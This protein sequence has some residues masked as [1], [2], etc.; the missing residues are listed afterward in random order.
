MEKVGDKI[1][2]Q[3]LGEIRLTKFSKRYVLTM[4]LD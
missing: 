4:C 3:V 2:K 1:V